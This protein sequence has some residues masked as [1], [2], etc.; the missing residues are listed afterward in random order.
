M[1]STRRCPPRSSLGCSPMRFTP[2]SYV[3][4]TAT[5]V[6]CAGRPGCGA[7]RRRSAPTTQPDDAQR[8]QQPGV[9][10]GRVLA[11]LLV[12][13]QRAVARRHVGT[14]D[15]LDTLPIGVAHR[16]ARAV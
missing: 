16:I 8:E 7:M 9:L 6:A 12:A 14:A 4:A 10:A 15:L 5:R 1:R 13:G 11:G 3:R 2:A